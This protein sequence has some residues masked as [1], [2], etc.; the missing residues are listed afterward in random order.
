MPDG[1]LILVVLALVLAALA[2]AALSRAALSRAAGNGG[3]SRNRATLQ[4][5][6]FAGGAPAARAAVAARSAWVTLVMRGDAYVPGALA[7]AASLRASGTAAATVCMVTDDV[8]A[9]ARALLGRAFDRV[10]AVDKLTY[11]ACPMR[12]EKQNALYG[13]WIADSFTKWRCLGFVEYAR[14]IFLDADTVLLGNC[15]HL[16]AVPAPAGIFSSPWARPYAAQES[17]GGLPNPYLLAGK[18]KG[19][20]KGAALAHGAAVPDAAVARG[21]RGAFVAFGT[22]L[23]LAPAPGLLAE[24]CAYCARAVAARGCVGSPGCYS[25]ADE[26]SIVGFFLARRAAGPAGAHGAAGA[27]G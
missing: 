13:S 19:E 12:T 11:P 16:F 6:K 9:G 10:V 21:L 5:C 15:D 8:S 26:Q 14:V 17:G 3:Q 18:H 27:V 24:F 25:G 2:L 1:W 7:L 23:L 4:K 22:T 20:H